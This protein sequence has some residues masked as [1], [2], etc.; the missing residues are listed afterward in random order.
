MCIYEHMKSWFWNT[1]LIYYLIFGWSPCVYPRFSHFANFSF[2]IF[3]LLYIS[4][5]AWAS[6]L[7]TRR[8]CASEDVAAIRET[9]LKSGNDGAREKQEMSEGEYRNNQDVDEMYS[10]R[11]RRQEEE[12]KY[13]LKVIKKKEMMQRADWGRNIICLWNNWFYV[14]DGNR[15]S[16]Q[17]FVRPPG[18]SRHKHMQ[19]QTSEDTSSSSCIKDQHFQVQCEGFRETEG[20]E[21]NM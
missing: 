6:R 11:K 13:E 20:Q 14:G 3:F 5:P 2:D 10:G 12:L 4:K 17:D 19:V 18:G 9:G 8:P 15:K 16:L 21:W 7:G 1:N